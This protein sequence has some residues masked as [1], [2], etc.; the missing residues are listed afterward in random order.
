[1]RYPINPADFGE[2]YEYNAEWCVDEALYPESRGYKVHRFTTEA[3]AKKF[4]DDNEAAYNAQKLQE[5]SGVAV[6]GENSDR[7]AALEALNTLGDSSTLPDEQRNERE[8]AIRATLDRIIEEQKPDVS[9]M[10]VPDGYKLVQI[11]PTESVIDAIHDAISG[12][13]EGYDGRML[14]WYTKIYKSAMLSAAP[15]AQPEKLDVEALKRVH[16]IRDRANGIY[17]SG[18]YYVDGWNEAIDHLAAIGR[19]KGCEMFYR[20]MCWLFPD[21]PRDGLA[22]LANTL[23]KAQEN[24]QRL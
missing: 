18:S 10:V 15:P 23:R 1:M 3:E 20:F 5:V 4:I 11:E 16:P 2:P 14:D 24:D 12:D 8:M 9:K 6:C 21:E 22:R 7:Q 13:S 19:L 17:S